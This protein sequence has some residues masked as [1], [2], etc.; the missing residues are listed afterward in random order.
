M[1]NGAWHHTA[2]IS[3]PAAG[4]WTASAASSGSSAYLLTISYDTNGKRAAKLNKAQDNKKL[5]LDV[6]GLRDE[7]TTVRYTVD[8]VNGKDDKSDNYQRKQNQSKRVKQ[9]ESLLADEIDIPASE[10]SGVY[11]VTAEIEGETD[12]D[13]KYRPTIVKSV[14]ID[15]NGN[16]YTP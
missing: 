12:E 10:G 9:Q 15:E 16:T 6:D 7:K 2:T 3:R 4:E 5:K 11:T 14:Y 8:F 13:F 1:L